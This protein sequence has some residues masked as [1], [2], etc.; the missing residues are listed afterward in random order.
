M[1]NPHTTNP[2]LLPDPG[3]GKSDYGVPEAHTEEEE[4]LTPEQMEAYRRQ[5]EQ[6][7]K[8]AGEKA[9]QQVEKPVTSPAPK[10]IRQDSTESR[11]D[12]ESPQPIFLGR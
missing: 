2:D 9:A 11:V 7:N 10:S 4:S 6:K 1:D 12:V 8:V 3:M 5:Q